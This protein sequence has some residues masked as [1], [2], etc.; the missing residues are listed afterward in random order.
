[1]LKAVQTA[2]LKRKP[3]IF[4]TFSRDYQLWLLVLPAIAVIFV[5]NYI[6]MYGIQLAF[7]EYSFKAGITGGNFAGMKYFTKYFTSNMFGPTILNTFAIAGTSILMGFPAPILLALL[8]NQVRRQRTKHMLQT[9]SYMPHFISTVVMVS[10]LQ[11]FLSN[12]GILSMALKGTEIVPKDLNLMGSPKAFVWVYVLSGIWQ[13]CGWDSIIYLAA[14]SSVDSQLYEA[15]R[16]DGANRL[17]ITWHIDIPTLVPTIVILL[18]LNCGNIL[19]VGFEKAFLMQNQM[20]LGVSQVISTYVYNAGVRAAPNVAPQFSYGA[21]IG[22]F[23]TLV[24]FVFLII[25]NLISK[26]TSNVSLW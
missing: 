3:T 13:N 7:R 23:N 8:F 1:V 22:L 16:I 5:F 21:A 18:I 25:V 15:C 26:K 20:N 12:T 24:N 14:L 17:Q 4:N 6:P 19:S 2:N 11:V 10:L 9:I